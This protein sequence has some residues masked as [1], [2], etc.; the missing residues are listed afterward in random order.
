LHLHIFLTEENIV[1]VASGLTELANTRHAELP[2]FGVDLRVE[3][4]GV[5][6]D[7]L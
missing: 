4:R 1:A 7:L 5:L 2:P 3:F 6:P